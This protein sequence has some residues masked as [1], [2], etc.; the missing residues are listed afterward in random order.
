MAVNTGVASV[1]KLLLESKCRSRD[2]QTSCW[3]WKCHCVMHFPLGL[4][5]IQLLAFSMFRV[6]F[7]A[8]SVCQI[9][10]LACSVIW[11]L[12]TLIGTMVDDT[13]DWLC[14]LS[15]S[16]WYNKIHVRSKLT[17]S[18]F[19]Q[20]YDVKTEN[21]WKRKLKQKNNKNVR[22]PKKNFQNYFILF[23]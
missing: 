22:N 7:P 23:I 20:T 19:G 12:L 15:V 14:S 6:D 5:Q 9:S 4:Q 13:M 21:W 17:G 11:R 16:C 1:I 3:R 2:S 10:D 8:F 18:H